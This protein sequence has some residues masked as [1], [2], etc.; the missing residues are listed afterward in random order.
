MS[1]RIATRAQRAADAAALVRKQDPSASPYMLMLQ[2]LEKLDEDIDSIH[3][4]RLQAV[5]SVLPHH[6]EAVRGKW[7]SPERCR[8]AAFAAAIEEADELLK[9]L[10]K[11]P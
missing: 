8:E 4:A 2:V 9:K 6:R 7:D 3:P 1:S 10:C 11:A 5:L